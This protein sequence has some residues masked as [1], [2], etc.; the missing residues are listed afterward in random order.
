MARRGKRQKA[1]WRHRQ[2]K[3]RVTNRRQH[4]G[5]DNPYGDNDTSF[6]PIESPWKGTDTEPLWA[7]PFQDDAKTLSAGTAENLFPPLHVICKCYYEEPC[8]EKPHARFWIGL[9]TARCSFTKRSC[10]QALRHIPCLMYIIN[11]RDNLMNKKRM[12]ALAMAV[13]LVCGLA[14][15]TANKIGRASCRER[16]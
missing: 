3:T 1:C 6:F 13:L 7:L 2:D 4:A 8:A 11:R 5:R 10:N 16:V 12:L 14:A 9:Y 15:C